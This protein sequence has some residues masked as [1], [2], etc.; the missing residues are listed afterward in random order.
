MLAATILC[1]FG[2]VASTRSQGT[3]PVVAIH[4]SE[5]TRALET[6]PASGATPTGSG[7][8]GNQWWLTQWHYFVMPDSVKEMLRSDGTT[9]TVVGDSNIISGVLTNSNGSPKYPILISLASEAIQNSEIAPLTNYV[10]AGGFLIVGSSAFTRNPDG[11]SRTNFALASA[12]GVNM[13]N[14]GLTNWSQDLTFTKLTNHLLVSHIPNG[15]LLW[16]MPSSADETTVPESDELTSL[17]PNE[18]PPATL[19]NLTWQVQASSATVLAQGDSSPYILIKKF[20]KGCFIYDAAIEPI[21]GHGGWAPSTYAYSIFRNAIEWAFQSNNLPVVKL[22]PWPYPYKAA[23]MFRHDLEAIPSL[24][25]SV[26]SSAQVENQNGARGEYY[27]CTGVLREDYSP[28]ARTN[29]IASLQRAITLYG[30]IVSSHNGGLTNINTYVPPLDI[31]ELLFGQDPN[32]YT[33]VNPYGYDTAYGFNAVDYSYWHWGPDQVLDD[34]NLPLGYTNGTQYAFAAISNSFLDLKGWGLTN[35]NITTFVSPNFNATREPSYQIEQQLGIKTTGEEKI[36]PFP[37]WVLSTETPDYRYPFITLP[38]SDWFIGSQI[39]QSME[40]GQTI[41]SVQQDVDYFYSLGALINIYG[42]SSSAGNAGFAG[43][44]YLEYVTYSMNSS[45]HPRLW[46]ANS[47]DIYSWWLQ[48]IQ[49]ADHI[50]HF[51]HQ[52]R[53]ITGHDQHFRG[54]S[55]QYRR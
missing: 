13:V 31:V 54:H 38:P 40:T 17:T 11:S 2:M 28:T 55:H 43:P 19:P 20:G 53:P 25:D 50:H 35:G 30:A 32:W 5:L 27:F 29:E 6:M 51:N 42:H 44:Q 24:I 33:S 1:F 18:T 16:Q 34:T 41:F 3:L 14:P 46:A 45:L 39:A 10:A 37:G 23:V 52:W 12:M 36:G 22:S 9:F 4:D 26:E 49:R 8:T 7:T 15:T 48:T 47:Q 21:M